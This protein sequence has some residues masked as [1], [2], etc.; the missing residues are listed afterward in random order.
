[1]NKKEI[2][3]K[4]RAIISKIEENSIQAWEHKLE[5]T[6]AV[7][8]LEDFDKNGDHS[9]DPELKTKYNGWE[10]DLTELLKELDTPETATLNDRKESGAAS[11]K[12]EMSDGNITV[13]HGTDD[14]VLHKIENA[15]QGSWNKLW[16]TIKSLK[17]VGEADDK[18]EKFFLF[19]E[20][21]THAFDHSTEDETHEQVAEKIKEHEYALF[22]WEE[23][24]TDPME[25]VIEYDGWNG[26]SEI[27]RELY[28]LLQPE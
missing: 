4:L 10:E 22:Y 11:L 27:S 6:K 1:M 12:I 28:T 14:V 8:V 2:A 17:S 9:D 3:D 21:S 5:Y 26:C 20:Y 13:I 16:E 18:K 7:V 24:I 23:G 19:G 15:K 25:L